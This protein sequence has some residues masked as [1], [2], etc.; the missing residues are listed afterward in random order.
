MKLFKEKKK[1][2]HSIFSATLKTDRGNNFVREHEEDFDFQTDHNNLCV[3]YATSARARV[4][5]SDTL[6]Y[7][8]SAKF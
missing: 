8:T 3:F 7:M 2:M 1:F 4:S 5:A 6:N